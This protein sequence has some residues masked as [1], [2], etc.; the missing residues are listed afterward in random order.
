MAIFIKVSNP[1]DFLKD[2]KLSINNGCINEWVCDMD[3]DFTS[4]IE[5]L[6]NEAWFHPY[7]CID[8][9]LIL[10]IVGRKNVKMP[11][12]LYSTLHSEF[13]KTLLI[14][15]CSQIDNI[16]IIPPFSNDYDT[17]TIEEK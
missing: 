17:H 8:N 16:L 7:T 10:G 11:M 9:I 3:G 4:T 5:N 14:H 6:Q 1:E 13:V 2:I 12:S 15:Y